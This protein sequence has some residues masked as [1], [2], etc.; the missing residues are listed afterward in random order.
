MNV[1]KIV[2]NI[3]CNGNAEEAGR[4]YAAVLPETSTRV[5]SRYPEEGLLDFQRPLAGAPLTVEVLVRGFELVLVNAG[6]EFRPNPAISFMLNFDPLLFDGD[7]Q[8]ARDALDELWGRLEAGGTVRMPL[9]EYPFSAHYGW[10][11]DRYGVSW[12][13]MLTDAAGEPRPFVIPALTFGGP[14]QNSAGEAVDHYVATL[15]DA[16]LG[17]RLL[18]AEAHGPAAAGSVQFS[19]FR[20]GEEWFT[21]FDAAAEQDFTFDCGVSLEVKCGDQAEIDRLWEALSSAPEA[22]QCGWC[23]DRFGVNWQIVPANMGE[24]MQRPGA[25]ERMLRMKKLVIDEL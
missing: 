12:Q 15:D 19:E 22:E 24:L 8:A 23:R 25:F 16:E 2:P 9:G 7:E 6:D 10:I 4:F 21:A 20:V 17:Q 11:E 3:W 1:Q 13:L 14:H 5:T 18:F